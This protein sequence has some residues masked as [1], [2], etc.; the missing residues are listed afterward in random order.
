[1]NLYLY[2]IWLLHEEPSVI[3]IENA[4]HF[5]HYI[6]LGRKVRPSITN[7]VQ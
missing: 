7:D 1:M 3:F 2:L 5:K 4:S 6:Y